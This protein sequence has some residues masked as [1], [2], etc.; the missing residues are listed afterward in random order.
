MHIKMASCY[1]L[2]FLNSCAFSLVYFSC[3]IMLEYTKHK[4]SFLLRVENFL[5]IMTSK[6]ICY[7]K[8]LCSQI[9]YIKFYFQFSWTGLS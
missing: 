9:L 3:C 6:K 8:I 1:G 7:P 2:F 5:G 4:E